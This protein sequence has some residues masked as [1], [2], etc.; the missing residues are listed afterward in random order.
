MTDFQFTQIG[1]IHSPYKEK[2]AVPRQPGLVSDGGGELHLLPPY[3]Q[4]DAV[5]GLEAFSHI[6]LLF[7]FHQTMEGGWRPM[8]R[9]PRLGGNART[10]V[11][12]TRSTF[13]PNPVGMSLVELKGIRCHKE[14]VILELGSLDL[15]DGTPVIDIKPYLPFAEALPEARAGYAQSAPKADMPVYFTQE[16]QQQ[17]GQLEPRYP[18]IAR[19]IQQVLAQ[20]PR[21]AYRKGEDSGKAYAVSLLDFNIRWRVSEHGFEVFAIEAG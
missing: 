13:R 14:S 11:F 21:P 5:R 17:L 2:F 16:I 6:W 7:V 8:V 9:P 15:V 4:A 20:D 12:A 10:G 19:F 3:N 1:C 18:H